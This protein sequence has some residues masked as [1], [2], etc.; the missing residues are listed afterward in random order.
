MADEA[1]IRDLVESYIADSDAYADDEVNVY[2][3]A[4]M[5]PSEDTLKALLEDFATYVIAEM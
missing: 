2:A 5:H 4:M 1:R 3:I